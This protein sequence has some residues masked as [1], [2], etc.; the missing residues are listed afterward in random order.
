MRWSCTGFVF[1]AYHGAPILYGFCRNILQLA[2]ANARA[3][4]GLQN[5]GNAAVPG[6]VYQ[7]FVFR[8]RQFALFVGKHLALN[9]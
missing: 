2:D 1:A 7:P 5:K 8:G 3:A 4:D 9:F 6:G